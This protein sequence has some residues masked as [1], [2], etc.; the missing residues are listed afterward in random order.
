MKQPTGVKKTEQ[1]AAILLICIIAIIAIIYLLILPQLKSLRENNLNATVKKIE[2]QEKEQKIDNL[3]S[4]EPEIKAKKE[5]ISKLSIAL[6]KN[7]RVDEILVQIS[8]MAS[9]SGMTLLS[10]SPSS[11]QN[12]ASTST[13]ETSTPASKE[14]AISESE[15][16]VD[17]YSLN[18][19][20]EGSY[21]SVMGFIY[22]IESNLRPIKINKADFNAGE[23]ANPLMAVSLEMTLYYQR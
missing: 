22:A 23:G 20:V 15:I 21:S 7:T 13:E 17:Q 9:S 2:L 18:L 4:L 8:A 3:K 14:E 6:P 19:S 1:V 5:I 11:K 10:F 16:I 12:I